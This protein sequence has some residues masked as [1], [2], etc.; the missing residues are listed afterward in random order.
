METI[1]QSLIQLAKENPCLDIIARL[2]GISVKS[3]ALFIAETRDPRQYR[4][5]KQIEKFAGYNLRI[6]DSGRSYGPRHISHIGNRRLRWILY[7]MTQEAVK[8][9]PEVRIKHLKR[10]IKRPNHRKNVIA[11]VTQLLKL[12]MALVKEQRHYE[13]NDENIKLM[14]QL[15]KQYEIIKQNR[16]KNYNKYKEAA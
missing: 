16:K 11:C 6:S 15:E 8:Y 5:F 10:Q 7:I 13:Y 4:H 9:I 1:M 12:I 2:K 14:K 3:T